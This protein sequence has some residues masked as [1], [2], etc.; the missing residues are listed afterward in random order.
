MSRAGLELGY[1]HPIGSVIPD[2]MT[3]TDCGVNH[4]KADRNT[5]RLPVPA[6]PDCCPC[7]GDRE[8]HTSSIHALG[9]VHIAITPSQYVETIQPLFV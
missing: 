3:L 9:G 2:L 6:N 8:T 1:W 7:L 5:V 4:Y